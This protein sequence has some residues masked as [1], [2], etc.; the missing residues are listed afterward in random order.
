MLVM[1]VGLILCKRCFHCNI[2]G[3]LG[4]QEL[5]EQTFQQ[6]IRNIGPNQLFI[7]PSFM[8]VTKYVSIGF[9]LGNQGTPKGVTTPYPTMGA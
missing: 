7:V 2:F 6:F 3:K 1:K 4:K 5:I 9:P 8:N